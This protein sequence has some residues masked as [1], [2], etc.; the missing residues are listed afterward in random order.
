MANIQPPRQANACHTTTKHIIKKNKN[1]QKK[2]KAKKE[3]QS[4]INNVADD[5]PEINGLQKT[6]MLNVEVREC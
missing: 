4:T 1:K 3:K 6:Q 5:K 2:N